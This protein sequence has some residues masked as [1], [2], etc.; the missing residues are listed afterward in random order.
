MISAEK[1][2]DFFSNTVKFREVPLTAPF[3]ILFPAGRHGEA[4]APDRAAAAGAAVWQRAGAGGGG[5]AAPG[6]GGAA[7][8]HPGPGGPPGACPV[9]LHEDLLTFPVLVDTVFICSVVQQSS[10]KCDP[11]VL[12]RCSR[13]CPRV[14]SCSSRPC[15]GAARP[16]PRPPPP[17]RYYRHPWANS[18]L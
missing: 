8:R 11:R 9:H 16:S 14:T 3:T 17:A 13:L 4:G 18:Q 12:C 2:P 7:A 5:G 10:V 6:A 1:C 15:P